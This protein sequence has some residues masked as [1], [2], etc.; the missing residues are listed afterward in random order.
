MKLLVEITRSNWTGN[1]FS[2]TPISRNYLASNI[3]P[4]E[5]KMTFNSYLHKMTSFIS[6]IDSLIT[7]PTLKI[8][9]TIRDLVKSKKEEITH[10]YESGSKYTVEQ[11]PEEYM[12]TLYITLGTIDEIQYFVTKSKI[13]MKDNDTNKEFLVLFAQLD[14]HTF[15]S[16]HLELSN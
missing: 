14:E 10:F 9:D 5:V 16:S 1:Y 12:K 8:N 6:N 2:V 15:I 3:R 11:I 4:S 13:Y 7:N